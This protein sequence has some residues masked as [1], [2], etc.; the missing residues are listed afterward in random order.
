M[1]VTGFHS[2][3]FL[4]CQWDLLQYQSLVLV[5]HRWVQP[6]RSLLHWDGSDGGDPAAPYPSGAGPAAAVLRH[7][8]RWRCEHWMSWIHRS[9][10]MLIYP[11][12]SGSLSAGDNRYLAVPRH[13][14]ALPCVQEPQ[15]GNV[16]TP[17]SVKVEG[18]WPTLQLHDFA[19]QCCQFCM[20]SALQTLFLASAPLLTFWS[21]QAA[22]HI[23]TAVFF[24]WHMGSC[25][26]WMVPMEGGVPRHSDTR[27]PGNRAPITAHLGLRLG[28]CPTLPTHDP[29]GHSGSSTLKCSLTNGAHDKHPPI[30]SSAKRGI[31]VN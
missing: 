30:R 31:R 21:R 23:N 24:L 1:V 25:G 4:C 13:R 10:F 2:C 16:P 12:A 3:L 14:A 7:A 9:A 26:H 5:C 6:F 17:S 27:C 15:G 22:I 20:Q 19:S 18:L 29:V 28:R 8:A 11:S